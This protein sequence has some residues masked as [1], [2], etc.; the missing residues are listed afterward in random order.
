MDTKSMAK[1]VGMGM[2]A[3][4]AVSMMVTPQRKKSKT[5]KKSNVSKAVRALGDVLEDVENALGW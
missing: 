2:V 1:A 3:G 5:L 4:A